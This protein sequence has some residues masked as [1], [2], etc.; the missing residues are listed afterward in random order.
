MGSEKDSNGYSE[1]P[2]PDYVPREAQGAMT[3]EGPRAFIG[4]MEEEDREARRNQLRDR[5]ARVYAETRGMFSRNLNNGEP[6]RGA[7]SD[8]AD[9]VSRR[10]L[11]Q[12][13]TT[14]KGYWWRIDPS[15]REPEKS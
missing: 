9:D 11:G 2:I 14:T 12:K 15:G 8:L 1:E 13:G 4:R 7:V 10:K 5:E 6:L 3:V